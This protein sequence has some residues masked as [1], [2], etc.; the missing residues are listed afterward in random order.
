M[1]SQTLSSFMRSKEKSLTQPVTKT[2]MALFADHSEFWVT[3]DLLK[4]FKLWTLM[5]ANLLVITHKIC[6]HLLPDHKHCK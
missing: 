2:L 4:S 5:I 3:D 6:K 1:Q